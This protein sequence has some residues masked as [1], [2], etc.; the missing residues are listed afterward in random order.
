MSCNTCHLPDGGVTD[1]SCIDCHG[2]DLKRAR[3]TH[4][5]SK[6]HDP[7]K[8][9]L[10]Q[11]IDAQNCLSCHQEHHQD[12]TH[13]M[14]V[15]VPADYC[16]HC[17]EDVAN[18]R[19]S[20]AG[21]AFDTC[22]NSGCHNYHDNTAIYENFLRKHHGE[23]STLPV[24]ENPLR[25]L[26]QWLKETGGRPEKQL[27]ASEADA[28]SE[29]IQPELVQQWSASGHAMA[30][31]NCSGCHS[32]ADADAV[33]TSSQ[34][35][36]ATP[37]HTSCESCHR[38]EVKGFLNG[39]HG[40]RLQIG[41][42]E[43]TP[44]LARHPMHSAAGHR[45]LNCSACHDPHQLNMQVAAVDACLSCHDDEHSRNYLNSSHFQL[46]QKEQRG[47]A[48]SGSG[49]SCATCHMP[50][51]EEGFVEHNQNDNLRPNE[52]MAR[53]VCMNCHGLQFTLDSLADSQQK[54][55]CYSAAPTSHVKSLEMVQEWFRSKQR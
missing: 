37:D 38:Q 3:D 36:H 8:A 13:P 34:D 40:M 30:G 54:S 29:W 6:F 35:F 18:D 42:S 52:K 44:D 14:G 15:T 43:M 25:R 22:A 55:Q 10:L 50:R 53:S 5:A 28:T 41:L 20:H 9:P 23:P 33:K 17:H 51:N 49:V 11:K 21:M 48:A 45:T 7:T 46:W 4:P 12:R 24:A 31:I 47:E 16:F 2:A 26:Q 39:R 19:P 1:Q 32:A 27:S